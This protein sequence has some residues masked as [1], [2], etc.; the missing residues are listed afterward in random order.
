MR[1]VLQ[2]DAEQVENAITQLNELI[3]EVDE[4]EVTSNKT[5]GDE[6]KVSAVIL[7]GEKG[8]ETLKTDMKELI[9]ATSEFLES[10]KNR[11]DTTDQT[12]ANRIREELK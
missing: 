12:I 9:Q 3:A 6:G 2:I 10:V 1:N 8:I 7:E 4:I 11:F 5:E